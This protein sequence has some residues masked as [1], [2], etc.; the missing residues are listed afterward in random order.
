MY[1]FEKFLVTE[2][3]DI[4]TLPLLH[5]CSAYHFEQILASGFLDATDCK[6]FNEKLLY[7]Y[8]GTPS[9]RLNFKTS[10][11]NILNFLVC[12]I[13]DGEKAKGLYKI[14]PFDSGAFIHLPEFKSLLTKEDTE[15]DNFQLSPELKSAKKIVKSFYKTNENYIRETPD[16]M[17]DIN[18]DQ[19]DLLDYKN[20][21]EYKDDSIIDN[22]KSTVELIFNT[23]IELSKDIIKQIIIPKDFLDNPKLI[24]L[25]QEKTGI[26]TP[27]TYRTCRGNP[28]EFFGL[29]RDKYLDF[30]D[31]L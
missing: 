26:D 17:I 27:L 4:K 20:I 19:E 11:S 25:I 9:Y 23:R 2:V 29:I 8:Y 3:D 16:L 6:V 7:T 5:N 30:E 13:I 1:P 18:D 22:R 10:T 31:L 21:I 24:S 12:F 28:N 15:I 14:F